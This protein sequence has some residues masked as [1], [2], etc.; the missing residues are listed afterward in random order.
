MYSILYRMTEKLYSIRQWGIN[1]KGEHNPH[2]IISLG[3]V[4]TLLAHT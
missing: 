4:T 3:G 1:L 2:E